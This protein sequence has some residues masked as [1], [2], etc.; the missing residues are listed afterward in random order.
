M[1]AIRQTVV[2][3]GNYWAF[4]PVPA[5]RT[6]SHVEL[7]S[8]F[9]F[10]PAEQ[11]LGSIRRKEWLFI[12]MAAILFQDKGEVRAEDYSIDHSSIL[13]RYE[14]EAFRR[15]SAGL[16]EV[17]KCKDSKGET[18]CLARREMPIFLAVGWGFARSQ[19]CELFGTCQHGTA[20]HSSAGTRHKPNRR[21]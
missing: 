2:K 3:L 10:L 4:C 1:N 12:H 14:F 8:F 20:R 16:Q 18:N 19:V 5:D 13:R 21:Q 6:Q 9:R 17:T 15:A 11:R 7:L